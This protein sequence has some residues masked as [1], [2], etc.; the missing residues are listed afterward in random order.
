M[1]TTRYG[2]GLAEAALTWNHYIK[3]T[4]RIEKQLS[5]TNYLRISYE[6]IVTNTIDELKTVCN[7]LRIPFQQKM[8][9][10]DLSGLS[11]FVNINDNRID[12]K[13]IDRYKL[14]LTKKQITLIEYIMGPY[15]KEYGYLTKDTLLQLPRSRVRISI[16]ALKWILRF[17]N[18]MKKASIFVGISGVMRVIYGFFRNIFKSD[19]SFSN[20]T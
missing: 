16:A 9:T 4:S 2:S 20:F 18:V 5:P 14:K 7:F 3:V 19:Q 11:S 6:K 12:T 17:I 1:I 15:L 8:L 10:A 13:R